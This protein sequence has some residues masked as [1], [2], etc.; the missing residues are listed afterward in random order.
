MSG[1]RPVRRQPVGA[2]PATGEAELRKL[3]HTLGV[4]VE[5]LDGLR[6]IPAADVSVLRTQIAEYLFQADKQ[7]FA[8]IAALS[9][10]VPVSVAAKLTEHAFPPLLAAR[11]AELID[12]R[13]AADLVSRI[14][15]AY[16]ADV[17]AAMDPSRAPQVIAQIPAARIALVGHELARRSEWVVIGGFITHVTPAAL[18]QTVQTFT[19][20]QLLHIGFVLD[21][22]DRLDAV[23]SLLSDEQIDELLGAAAQQGL[24]A[25]CSDLLD[26]VE[27][28]RLERLSARLA[29]AAESV[30]AAFRAALAEG[31]LDGERYARL[32]QHDTAG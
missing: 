30:R 6:S 4:Q 8:K 23:V 7:H 3:A 29:V 5:R 19:G 24:W 16:L 20:E 12:P 10:A 27:P 11:T 18:A 21:D 15:D 13:K 25:E 28:Q 9:S 17:S 14:S 1:A 22:K 2:Q 26:H 31:N 32:A